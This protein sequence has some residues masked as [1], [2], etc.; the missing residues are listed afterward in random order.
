MVLNETDIVYMIIHNLSTYVWGN[1]IITSAVILTFFILIGLFIQIP[2]PFILALCIPM[3]IVLVAY[4]FLPYFVGGLIVMTFLI[5]AL[6]SFANGVGL[7][8]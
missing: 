4:G 1:D 5:L 8:N 6:W 3:C 2:I 7:N